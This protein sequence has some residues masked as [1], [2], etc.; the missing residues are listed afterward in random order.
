MEAM[1]LFTGTTR[2]ND[3]AIEALRKA[4]I[5]FIQ[6]IGEPGD[7]PELFPH[8][9]GPVTGLIEILEYAKSHKRPKPKKIKS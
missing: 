6:S 7:E 8:D 4:N 3:R 1:G 5:P 2:E 9:R